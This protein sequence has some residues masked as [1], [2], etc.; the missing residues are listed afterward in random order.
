MS[1][2]RHF[3]DV[4]ENRGIKLT[5]DADLHQYRQR[6]REGQVQH[7]LGRAPAGAEV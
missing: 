4:I 5:L 6:A 3:A 2:Y 7:R 1:A